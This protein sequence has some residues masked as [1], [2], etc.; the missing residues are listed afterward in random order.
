MRALAMELLHQLGGLRGPEIGNIFGVDYS[1]VSQARKRL[2]EKTVCDQ[3]L[4][5][6]IGRIEKR[7]STVKI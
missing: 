3:R 6:T 5:A 1:L 2:R 7:M 4:R